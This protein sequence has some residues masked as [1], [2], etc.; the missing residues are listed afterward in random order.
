MQLWKSVA[1]AV[2]LALSGIT[3]ASSGTPVQA[4]TITV[5]KSPSCGCCTA[6]VKHL[7]RHQFKVVVKQTEDLSSIKAQRHVPDELA[8]CHT[9]VVGDYAIE[10]HVPASEVKR[11]LAERP[12]AQGIAVPGMPVG[13]PGME[14]GN[15]KDAYAVILFD[16]D[17]RSVFAQY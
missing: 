7:Q 14:Q 4:A 16:K 9:A 15:Q 12:K 6:W 13:S 3:A 2:T 8:S 17:R 1:I 10:G 11:L 5:Y